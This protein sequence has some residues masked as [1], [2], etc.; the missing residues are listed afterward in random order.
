MVDRHAH[1]LLAAKYFEAIALQNLGKAQKFYH[2]LFTHQRQLVKKGDIFLKAATRHVGANEKQVK[3][4][5]ESKTIQRKINLDI[6]EAK[7][8]G[9]N[10]SPNFLINGVSIK[11]ASTIADLSQIIE[12]HLKKNKK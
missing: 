9:F 11:G 7:K 8:F 2:Y 3:K 1:S 12:R 5:L 10:D 6:A 4:D